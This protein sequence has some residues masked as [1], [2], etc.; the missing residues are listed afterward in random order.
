[1]TD[2]FRY[3]AKGLHSQGDEVLRKLHDKPIEHPDVQH[4]R[5]EIMAAIKLEEEEE[6]K[7]NILDLFWDRSDIR[8]GRRIRVGFLVLAIQQ[9]MGI[10]LSVYYSTVIFEQVGLS[11]F[12][13]SLL[14]A[15]M[16]TAF[17]AGTFFLPPTIERWGRRAIMLWSAIVIT[18]AMLIFT[19][20]VN[21]PNKSTAT[22]WT[23][24]AAINVYNFVLG[25]GWVGIPWLYGPEVR[26]S[27]LLTLQVC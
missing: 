7:F 16:N 11:P 26:R 23:G 8:A 17:A 27:S 18:I 9:L 1:M 6:N 25:Y 19:T 20:M 15:V 5:A 13:A 12:L 24:I 14:A 21:L 22:Q 3:Y 2:N 10:N 4:M